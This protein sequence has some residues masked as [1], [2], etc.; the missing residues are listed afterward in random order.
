MPAQVEAPVNL[1]FFL[2]VHWLS[3]WPRVEGRSRLPFD[4]HVLRHLGRASVRGV[5]TNSWIARSMTDGYTDAL[6]KGFKKWAEVETW[7]TA[8]LPNSPPRPLPAPSRAS[9][10]SADRTE[11]SSS[12]A[13]NV[14]HRAPSPAPVDDGI[15]VSPLPAGSPFG[16]GVVH[17]LPHPQERGAHDPQPPSQ[18]PS[19]RHPAHP[20]PAHPDGACSWRPHRHSS[21]AGLLVTRGGIARA[22]ARVPHRPRTRPCPPLDPPSVAVTHAHPCARNNEAPR[23]SVL[24]TPSD[25]GAQA[26]PVALAPPLPAAAPEPAPQMFSIRGVS[27]FYPTHAAAF[28]GGEAPQHQ[29]APHQ[30][31]APMPPKLTAWMTLKPLPWTIVVTRS[32]RSFLDSPDPNH[33]VFYRVLIQASVKYDWHTVARLHQLN[34]SSVAALSVTT[35]AHVTQE[36]RERRP[37][38]EPKKRGQASDFQGSREVFLSSKKKGLEAKTDGLRVF[39]S[40]LFDEYF[41]VYPWDLPLDQEPDPNAIPVRLPD[42]AEEAL[43]QMGFNDSPEDKER[44]GKAKKIESENQALGNPFFEH[45]S[46]L[47]HREQTLA[48]KRMSDYQYYMQHK[49]FKDA[50]RERFEDEYEEGESRAR[51]IDARCRIAKEMLEDE[52]QDVRDRITRECDKAH[53]GTWRRSKRMK[54]RTVLRLSTQR[55]RENFLAIV[56][57]LLA[58]LHAYTG[59]TLNII[60]GRINEDTQQFETMSANAGV[61]D[62]KDW[63]RWDPAGYAACPEE[64]SKICPCRIFGNL[65]DPG[66]SSSSAAPGAWA[67]AGAGASSAPAAHGIAV[68]PADLVVGMNLLQMP[69]K[70]DVDMPRPAGVM[71]EG[72]QEVVMGPP[73]LPPL[74]GDADEL[75]AFTDAPG[76]ARQAEKASASTTGNPALAKSSSKPAKPAAKAANAK[77]APAAP[78][79]RA[80]ASVPVTSAAVESASAPPTDEDL[81]PP[82]DA[83]RK[84]VNKMVLPTM[85]GLEGLN[86]AIAGRVAGDVGGRAG[87][88]H[89]GSLSD[90]GVRPRARDESRFQQI[91]A[92]ASGAD[93]GGRPDSSQDEGE[94]PGAS[95]GTV[96]GRVEVRTKV[97]RDGQEGPFGRGHAGNEDRLEGACRLLVGLEEKSSFASSTKSHA[98]T[99]RPKAVGVWVKNTRK[100]VP[101]IGTSEDMEQE[102]WGWWKA[103]NPGWRTPS[104]AWKD[105]VQDVTWALAKLNGKEIRR[106]NAEASLCLLM[107]PADAPAAPGPA[108]PVNVPADAP[109]APGPALPANVPVDAPAATDDPAREADK[110][111]QQA[112]VNVEPEPQS[113]AGSNN[114]QNAEEGAVSGGVWR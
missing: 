91:G 103:I 110:G 96:G 77:Q 27:V 99:N 8:L 86:F 32:T 6:A 5:Y 63:A 3:P 75:M 59:L 60:G 12:A 45:L 51:Q 71:N 42:T 23:P 62:G 22:T 46:Q 101:S 70:E 98:T 38:R 53:A 97:G 39:W 94:G 41:K 47:R 29:G 69:P 79:P 11:L 2:F 13:T 93:P 31:L 84:P 72:S 33:Y 54:R 73:P 7:W 30:W 105:A 61:V 25:R 65:V 50:V 102:W 80:T 19:P 92:G 87:A 85:W 109:A 52:P 24:V 48:P 78:L 114:V 10:S 56:Q 34:T 112:A 4:L 40:N 107:L 58:G 18:R 64:L 55:C 35:I 28:D 9:S 21:F 44:Q 111:S 90:V 76:S 14:P 15:R 67:A 89:Q 66:A 16:A 49:E 100:G 43:D 74:T 26:G 37:K 113:R 68:N 88:A 1:S 83:S 104:D 57:P 20:R 82:V 95:A 81:L 36:T 17:G 108:L 106:D